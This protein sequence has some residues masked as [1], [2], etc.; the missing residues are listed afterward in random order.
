MEPVRSRW[1]ALLYLPIYL[2]LIALISAI[3][4]RPALL[5]VCC[6]VLA[7]GMLLRWHSRSDV[8]FFLLASSL[9]PLGESVAISFG[10]WQ[11]ALPWAGIP[12]WLPVGWGVAGLYLKKTSEVLLGYAGDQS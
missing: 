4:S 2:L 1:R 10:A 8:L 11:Y 6:G 12:L 5:T 7:G 3:W 9:G